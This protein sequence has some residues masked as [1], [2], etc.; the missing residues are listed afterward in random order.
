VGFP[1][2]AGFLTGSVT[3]GAQYVILEF[4]INNVPRA[5]GRIVASG[6]RLHLTPN[7]RQYNMGSIVLV[8]G[9]IVAV[10]PEILTHIK[11]NPNAD[12]DPMPKGQARVHVEG[13]CPAECLSQLTGPITLYKSFLHMHSYGRE[14]WTTLHRGSYEA[15]GATVTP[16]PQVLSYKQFWNFDFQT[17]VVVNVSLT[18]IDSLSTHCVYDVS[19]PLTIF[20]SKM[21]NVLDQSRRQTL[22]RT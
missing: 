20:S 14:M 6:V 2:E 4:H 16:P 22:P 19:F 17:H 11:G 3:G 1:P 18:A 7:L 10:G 9:L 15:N 12:L 8:S 13:T 5:S 21:T